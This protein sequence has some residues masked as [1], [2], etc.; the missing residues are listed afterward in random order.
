MRIQTLHRGAQMPEH[1]MGLQSLLQLLA[2]TGG[3]QQCQGPGRGID[4]MDTIAADQQIVG[5]FAAD[6]A[7]AY[8]QHGFGR[9]TQRLVKLGQI[10]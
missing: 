6:Q 3:Q 9:S 5:E 2:G 1:T 10:L 7:C 8:D 4:H